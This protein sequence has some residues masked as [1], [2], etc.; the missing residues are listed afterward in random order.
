[1]VV[2]DMAIPSEYI[3]D[4]PELLNYQI[5]FCNKCQGSPCYLKH[6]AAKDVWK[7]A[8]DVLAGRNYSSITDQQ[9]RRAVRYPL[10]GGFFR[11]IYGIG[12]KRT[13]ECLPECVTDKIKETYPEP[14]GDYVGFKKAKKKE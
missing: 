2:N 6:E 8:V 4:R 3:H 12:K 14:D 9:E 13:R 7:K 1:M 11:I 5:G 10:Y